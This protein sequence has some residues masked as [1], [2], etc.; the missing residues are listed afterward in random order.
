LS[1]SRIIRDTMEPEE[2]QRIKTVESAQ[3]KEKSLGR[4]G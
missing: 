1:T 3:Q 4:G 2:R